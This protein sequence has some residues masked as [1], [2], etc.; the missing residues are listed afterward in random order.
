MAKVDPD[1]LI[2]WYEQCGPELHLYALQWHG[3]QVAEDL[4]QDAFFKLLS[5][6]Q[7]PERVKPWLF[8]VVRNSAISRLRQIRRRN[9]ID[10]QFPRVQGGLAGVDHGRATRCQAGS[11]HLGDPADRTPGNC[12]HADLG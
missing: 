12:G 4:V 5:L 2:E 1:K 10:E 11:G 9:E 7:C 8:R 6:R 3:V